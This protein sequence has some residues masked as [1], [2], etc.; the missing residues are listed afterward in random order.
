MALKLSQLRS[1]SSLGKGGLFAYKTTDTIATV[2]G[3]DYFAAAAPRLAIGDRIDVTVVTNLETS[4]E[5]Y[6]DDGQYIVTAV[7]ST[8]VT[9]AAVS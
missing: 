9:I 2:E 4:S 6:A 1:I 8:S 7:S 5:T 3:P